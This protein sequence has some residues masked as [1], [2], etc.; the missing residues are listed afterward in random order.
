ML[1]ALDSSSAA[2]PSF[3]SSAGR[4]GAQ[5]GHDHHPRHLLSPTA[6]T[7]ER[8]P[9]TNPTSARPASAFASKLKSSEL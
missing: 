7:P 4:H 8:A 6:T 2:S 3:S 9:L 5:A 1:K